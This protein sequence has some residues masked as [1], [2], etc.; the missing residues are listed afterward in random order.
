[1]SEEKTVSYRTTNSYETCNTF[2]ADTQNI[3]LVFHG[4]GHLSRYFIKH[5]E[6]LNPAENYIIAPQATSL[7]YQD[8]RYKYVG[9]CWLTRENLGQGIDNNHAYLDALYEEELR[10]KLKANRRLIIMGFSQGVSVAMRWLHS[11]NLDC[12]QIILHSGS[13]PRSFDVN[14][15]KELVT[16]TPV[17][18]YGA[19]DPL[20][21]EDRLKSEMEY[22]REIFGREPRVIRFDGGH[23]VD[24]NSLKTLAEETDRAEK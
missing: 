1:M 19:K 20:I 24:E 13:I 23:E 9:A 10:A 3:W 15:F 7:Y 18:V 4:L 11:R 17:L 21:T 8:K 22:A 12:D 5:F 6:M 16:S 14:A 2:T